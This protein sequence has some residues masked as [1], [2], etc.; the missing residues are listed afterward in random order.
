MFGETEEGLYTNSTFVGIAGVEYSLGIVWDTVRISAQ[1]RMPQVVPVDS[2]ELV[3]SQSGFMGNTAPAYSL[4]VHYTD[5][6]N[7]INYYRFD[8]Y[9]NDSLYDGFVVSKDLFYNGIST[10]QFFMNYEMQPQDTIN[11]V[12]S[13]IDEANYNYFLVLSQG[14]SPFNIAPGNPVSNLKGGAL[15]YFGA[16]AQSEKIFI[17][18]KA[19]EQ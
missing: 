9:K 1:S 6:A 19:E 10:Y 12:L 14:G 15:G 7:E 11:V 17:V 8:V 4:K 3:V 5:P 18:P 16:F 13:A 2:V